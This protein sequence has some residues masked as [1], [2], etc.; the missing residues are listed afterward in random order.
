VV[1]RP[2]RSADD[3]KE[4]AKAIVDEMAPAEVNR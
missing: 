3:P 1:G 2:I 4:A